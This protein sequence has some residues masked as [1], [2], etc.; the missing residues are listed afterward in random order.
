MNFVYYN[1]YIQP[2]GSI[3]APVAESVDAL[4][5]KSNWAYNPVPVQ[6]WPGANLKRDSFESLL[7]YSTKKTANAVFLVESY[8]FNIFIPVKFFWLRNSIFSGVNI[9]SLG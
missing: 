5:L 9:L 6:V 7:L 1:I 8:L 2:N 3:H 4:D